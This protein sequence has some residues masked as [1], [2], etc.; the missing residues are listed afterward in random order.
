MT[1][2]DYVF[3]KYLKIVHIVSTKKFNSNFKRERDRVPMLKK[4][5]TYTSY[6]KKK[7]FFFIYPNISS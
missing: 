2:L 6:P 4:D 5:H 3:R 7:N 1:I